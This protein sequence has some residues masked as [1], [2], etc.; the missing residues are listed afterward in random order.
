M[1]GLRVPSPHAD[2]SRNSRHV[3]FFVRRGVTQDGEGQ[4]FPL[5]FTILCAAISTSYLQ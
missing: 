5:H 4:A 1:C 3:E 2:I